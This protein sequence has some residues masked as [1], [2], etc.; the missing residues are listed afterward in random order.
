MRGG[1]R[2]GNEGDSDEGGGTGLAVGDV[3]DGVDG[4]GKKGVGSV[5]R[6]IGGATGGSEAVGGGKAAGGGEVV[7]GIG[8][9]G[10]G[11]GG[12][13]GK[14][15]SRGKGGREGTNGGQQMPCGLDVK[16]ARHSSERSTRWHMAHSWAQS[17]QSSFIQRQDSGKGPSPHLQLLLS[18]AMK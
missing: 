2:S 3:E 16:P 9:G 4:V 11:G 17:E 15:L 5:G 10:A 12:T 1:G 18:H 6:M 13:Y 7:G 14:N 8:G